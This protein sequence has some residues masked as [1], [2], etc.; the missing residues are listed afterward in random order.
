MNR[1]VENCSARVLSSK[2]RARSDEKAAARKERL[3]GKVS[4]PGAHLYST[5]E[6]KAR[7]KGLSA[8]GSR[9]QRTKKDGSTPSPSFSP[10]L[11]CIV[12]DKVIV[13]L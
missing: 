7:S 12:D 8:K 3:R 1:G 11:L 6:D 9:R 2:R 13:K 4:V 5:S 10:Y